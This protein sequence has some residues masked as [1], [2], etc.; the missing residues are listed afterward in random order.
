MR[1]LVQIA[2]VLMVVVAIFSVPSR[3][4]SASSVR[5][6]FEAA[7]VKVSQDNGKSGVQ[8]TTGRLTLEKVPLRVMVSVM[9]RRES[10][11]L[12]G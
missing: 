1:S 11:P 9:T 10:L 6:E 3:A 7:T 4:Q 5:P 8:G 2:G 12:A